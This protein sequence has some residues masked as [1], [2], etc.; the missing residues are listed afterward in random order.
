[1][2]KKRV[3]KKYTAQQR[4]EY[5]SQRDRAC[6]KFGI[7][8]GSPKHC[9]SFGFSDAFSGIDN[10]GATKFEF[11]N[12]SG[13]AYILGHKRGVKAA[14]EYFNKTGKQPFMLALEKR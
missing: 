9:Y 3:K 4:Y 2:A 14:R 5:H 10:S 12:K 11:G 7:K 1:M 6:G 8:F 13:N